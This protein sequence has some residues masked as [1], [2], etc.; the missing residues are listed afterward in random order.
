MAPKRIYNTTNNTLLV[1]NLQVAD[2]FW[3][4]LKGLL[5]TA[6]FPAGQGLLITPCRS[7]H[8]FGM[9][10]AIDVV[11]LDRDFK[12]L[13]ILHS[14]PPMATARCPGSRHVLELP[15]GTLAKIAL[16]LSDQLTVIENGL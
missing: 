2:T 7:I 14:L 5:G 12:V 13:K 3:S 8:M 4:R 11:F 6:S 9:R 15:G 16:S 10:Y 1:Q